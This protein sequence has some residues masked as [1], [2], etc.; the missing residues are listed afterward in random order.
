MQYH[1]HQ[2]TR[3]ESLLRKFQ[4]RLGYNRVEVEGSSQ[5]EAI[6][7]AKRRLCLENPRMWDV[8]SRLEDSRFTVDPPY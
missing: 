5:Q 2:H 1:D 7:E 6:R 3:D 8:I 4:V